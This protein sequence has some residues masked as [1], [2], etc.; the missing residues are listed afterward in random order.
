M[1]NFNWQFVVSFPVL[2]VECRTKITT[3]G[4]DDA[5]DIYTIPTRIIEDYKYLLTVMANQKTYKVYNSIHCG[6]RQTNRNCEKDRKRG[7]VK[8]NKNIKRRKQSDP[9]SSQTRAD[10]LK[11]KNC[12]VFKYVCC[13]LRGKHT[14]RIFQIEYLYIY[15]LQQQLFCRSVW[16]PL[17]PYR[18]IGGIITRWL[19]IYILSFQLF[20]LCPLHFFIIYRLHIAV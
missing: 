6:S 8:E 9:I 17:S 2:S 13:C 7:R 12:F 18:S 14:I 15:L 3:T 4:K 16:E 19:S 11:N 1:T 10:D 20:L 5:F